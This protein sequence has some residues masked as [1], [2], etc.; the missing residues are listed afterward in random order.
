[1]LNEDLIC[2]ICNGDGCIEDKKGNTSACT[3]C[4]GRGF[5]PERLVIH[6]K[7]SEDENKA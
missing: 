2:H 7:N 4:H 3:Y 6:E 5:L 1:M